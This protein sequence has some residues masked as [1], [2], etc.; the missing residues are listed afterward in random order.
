MECYGLFPLARLRSDLLKV[1]CQSGSVGIEVSEVICVPGCSVGL[2]CVDLCFHPGFC[3]DRALVRVL[4][5][6]SSV[7]LCL[8]P[9]QRTLGSASSAHNVMMSLPTRKL[10]QNNY[11]D[12][13]GHP[14]RD[15]ALGTS[16]GSLYLR[17][18]QTVVCSSAQLISTEPRNAEKASQEKCK[19]VSQCTRHIFQT[20]ARK[21]PKYL[22]RVTLL[23]IC[24]YGTAR[25]IRARWTFSHS[26][27]G[28]PHS[29][30]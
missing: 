24:T 19:F 28:P 26:P 18:V 21:A 6:C 2:R 30:P 27:Q 15:S 1:T 3:E 12:N 13:D 25:P 16:T 9:A 11:G 23:N 7:D 22:L 10:F 4:W 14:S 17:M 8:H 20:E 29:G 5:G